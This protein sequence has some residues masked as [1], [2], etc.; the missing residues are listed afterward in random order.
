MEEIAIIGVGCKL[1][2][3]DNIDQ[4]WR[5]LENGENHVLEVP[6]DRWNLDAFY[7]PDP[8]APG[9]TYVRRAGFIKNHDA[10]DNKVYGVN[11]F[12]AS[13][14]DP[15][16]RFVLDCCFK[17]MEN[18]GVT[19][20]SV[21]GSNTGV[22]IG[23]M[24]SDY[25]NLQSTGGENMNNYTLTGTS[26]SIVAARI[27][28][29]FNLLG[30]AM[31]L[32]TACSS[33]LLAIHLAAQALR[34]GDCD[35]ALAGGVN[36][37]MSPSIFVQLSKAR[38]AS[39]TGYCQAFSSKADGYA[40][41]EGAGIILLK[42]L[43][44]AVRDNDPIWGTIMTGSN[45]DGHTVTPMTAPSGSQQFQLLKKVYSRYNIDPDRL[46]YIEAHGTGTQAGDP[47]EA[48]CLGGFLA[49]HTKNAPRYIGSVK[50]NIGH[51]ESA[52]GVAGVIKVLLMQKHSLI[53]PT[54]HFDTPNEKIDF[55]KLKLIVATRT[56]KWP[57]YNYDGT[58]LS[59]VNSFSF[60]GT[61]CHAIIKSYNTAKAVKVIDP[62][63]LRLIC[64][65]GVDET[66][67]KGSI[68]HFCEKVKTQAYSIDDVVF[69]STIRRD[70]Y[71]IRVAKV[72][73]SIDDAV[74]Q[75]E[76]KTTIDK[77]P[78]KALQKPKQIIFV[79]C[80][81]GSTWKGMCKEHMKTNHVFY[82]KILEVDALLLPLTGWS[83][84]QRFED[85]FDPTDPYLGPIASFT[86][87][88]ALDAVW[89]YWGI[90]PD[91]VV[92][93]SVGE[94]A[95]SY[96]AGALSLKDAVKVIY[97]RTYR[98]ANA[99]GGS[100]LVVGN[101]DVSEVQ[102]IVD[103]YEG[104]VVIAVHNSPKSCT[105]SGDTDVIGMVKSRIQSAKE[106]LEIPLFLH[107]LTVTSAFH[108]HHMTECSNQIKDDL[109]GLQGSK[110][111]VKL[112]STVSA[113][114]ATET[115]FITAEYWAKNVRGTVLFR[116]A[117]QDAQNPDCF[118]IF[119]E[120][121]P[122]PVLIA[123]SKENFD[124][125]QACVLISMKKDIETNCIMQNLAQLY[126][127]GIDP[128]WGN[129]AERGNVTDVPQY[130]FN[131]KSNLIIPE[132]SKL[133]LM[134]GDLHSSGHPFLRPIIGANKSYKVLINPNRI[135][136]VYEHFV[137]DNIFIPGAFYGEVGLAI[138]EH[139]TSGRVTETAVSI[140]F[141]HP[142]VLHPGKSVELDVFT[143][144]E[145]DYKNEKEKTNYTVLR[146]NKI[147]AVGS[148]SWADNQ[149][150]TI[151][152]IDEIRDRCHSE[153]SQQDIY[154]QLKKL[155]FSYG[156]P[157]RV[158][159][160]AVSNG[161]ECLVYFSLPEEIRQERIGTFIHPAI[162]DGM[163]QTPGIL[164]IDSNS[165]GT[166]ILP[167][168]IGRLTLKG[169]PK[170]NMVAYGK[171]VK[172]TE[173]T[174]HYD[175]ILL[176]EDGN[177]IAEARNFITQNLGIA[178]ADKNILYSIHWKRFN[179]L[180]TED[181][182]NEKL[183]EL[184][185]LDNSQKLDLPGL[186]VLKLNM[187]ESFTDQLLRL[188]QLSNKK[189]LVYISH[190]RSSDG[191]ETSTV[192]QSILDEC[193]QIRELVLFMLA[194]RIDIPL[195][196][197]TLD[198]WIL[199]YNCN[200][201]VG[202]PSA[203]A[204]WGML[205]VVD[206][207]LTE[208]RINLVD[209][210][211]KDEDVTADVLYNT[212]NSIRKNGE[213]L[214]GGEFL[215]TDNVVYSLEILHIADRMEHKYRE[216]E[217]D[218]KCEVQLFSET[219][220]D[221]INPFLIYSDPPDVTTNSE[222]SLKVDTLAIQNTLL[223]NTCTE[224]ITHHHSASFSSGFP[225]LCLE[226]IGYMN[227]M[228]CNEKYISC[229]PTKA[230]TTIVVPRDC[231]ISAE[232][233]PVYHPGLMMKIVLMWSLSENVPANGVTLLYNSRT[234][235]L[236][237]LMCLIL[238]SH[239]KTH[240][241]IVSLDEIE[242]IE[243]GHILSLVNLSQQI[244]HDII[245]N[246]SNAHSLITLNSL[247]D[248]LGIAAVHHNRP[249]VATQILRT[250]EVYSPA[251]LLQKVPQIIEWIKS[252]RDELSAICK[253]FKSGI[254]G[255][256]RSSVAI[257]RSIDIMRLLSVTEIPFSRSLMLPPVR[258]VSGN[259]FRKDA[260]YIV[261]GGLTG[262]GWECVQ[263]L[264][265][266][267]AGHV[268]CFNRRKP[269][270]ENLMNIYN[271]ESSSSCRVVTEQVDVTQYDSVENAFKSVNN[272]FP[273]AKI[274]G[275]IFGAAVLSDAFI[276]SMDKV[277]FA[278]ALSPK[279]KGAWN[280]HLLTKDL[281]LDYFVMHSS[282]AGLLGN[283]GQSNYAAGNAFEDGLTHF[284]RSMGLPGQSFNWG[285]L[286][287]G[288]LKEAESTVKVIN[289]LKGQGYELLE[290][291]DIHQC[292]M[293][294]LLDNYPQVMCTKL[295][296][297]SFS[298]G[299][300][301][302]MSN[303][304]TKFLSI[305][306]TKATKHNTVDTADKTLQ[307]LDIH[308]IKTLEKDSRMQILI[309]YMSVIT[310]KVFAIDKS[311]VTPDSSIVDLGIDSMLAMTIIDQINRD[312]QFR[313]PMVVLLSEGATISKIAHAI[314]ASFWE[315]VDDDGNATSN[316]DKDSLKE[317]SGENEDTVAEL[318]LNKTTEPE[319]PLPKPASMLHV[320]PKTE[321][322][323]DTQSEKFQ[324]S[325]MVDI[326]CGV[327]FIESDIYELYE[328][329][330]KAPLHFIK[331]IIFKGAGVDLD[332]IKFCARQI[333]DIH[334]IARTLFKTL[335]TKSA[336]SGLERQIVNKEHQLDF[337]TLMD[338]SKDEEYQKLSEE[339]FNLEKSG[340]VRFISSSS[341]QS[342][343]K[344]RLVCHAIGFDSFALGKFISDFQSLVVANVS[345]RN[346]PLS[347]NYDHVGVNELQHIFHSNQ[348]Q[349]ESFWRGEVPKSISNM[350]LNGN[351]FNSS[352]NTTS[353]VTN[354]KLDD[355]LSRKIFNLGQSLDT[356]LLKL[357]VSFYQLLLHINTGEDLVNV[358]TKI[359]LRH[360]LFQSGHEVCNLT[361]DIPLFAKIATFSTFSDFIRE[362]SKTIQKYLNN[363]IYP[364][365]LIEKMVLSD[366]CRNNLKR[367]CVVLEEARKT[368]PAKSL[369]LLH[370]TLLI[371]NSNSTTKSIDV[372]LQY[373]S[374]LY[375][376]SEAKILLDQLQQILLLVTSNFDMTII[377]IGKSVEFLHKKF[378]GDHHG[379]SINN[380]APTKEGAESKASVSG[381]V[382]GAPES[383][384]PIP[385]LKNPD[386]V[387]LPENTL[388]YSEYYFFERYLRDN[389]VG[390]HMITDLYMKKRAGFDK[391]WHN[392][393]LKFLER[394]RTLRT[395]YVKAE[396]GENYRFGFK[397]LEK[398]PEDILDF[399]YVKNSKD[400]AEF[401]KI[402]RQ[403][404]D[405]FK[406][407]CVR[408]IFAGEPDTRI[409]FVFQHTGVDFY[410]FGLLLKDLRDITPAIGY[411]VDLPPSP[412]EQT[413]RAAL[414]V[415]AALKPM[416]NEMKK[417]WQSK[418]KAGVP[419]LTLNK[420]PRD[421]TRTGDIRPIISVLPNNTISDIF[422]LMPHMKTTV[423]KF[424]ASIYQMYFHF[425]TGHEKV[426]ISAPLDL[427]T[428][429]PETRSFYENMM[430]AV[431]FFTEF[432]NP[433]QTAEEFIRTNVI[434]I[435]QCLANG[436]YSVVLIRKL[437]ENKEEGKWLTRHS[438]V[439]ED[440]ATLHDLQ[441]KSKQTN[442]VQRTLG[443]SYETRLMVWID[444][445]NSYIRLHLECLP[446]LYTEEEAEGH[447]NNIVK[448]M[449]AV[450]KNSNQTLSQLKEL[451][452]PKQEIVP[453]TVKDA[454]EEVGARFL[455]ETSLGYDHLV[456]A[457]VTSSS[458]RPEI[459]W[460]SIGYR[461]RS[462]PKKFKSL[463]LAE[464]NKVYLAVYKGF[465]TVVFETRKKKFIFKFIDADEIADFTR[466]LGNNLEEHPSMTN[467]NAESIH[468]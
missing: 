180:A 153:Y 345:N 46:E 280:L 415:E 225:V 400:D 44:D 281:N 207:E 130:H 51:L 31:A 365:S 308:L 201:A 219:K 94:V 95:A 413:G 380:Y 296:L 83:I 184:L 392:A 451:V 228:N 276:E 446:E 373:R 377:N 396:P 33:S 29:T 171:I 359:N 425:M 420:Y 152:D 117:L 313:I 112:Y 10:W 69:T 43:K 192:F 103:D 58:K 224:N 53:V 411:G 262:L 239:H 360:M 242:T 68:Q 79:F 319:E 404:F 273:G 77:V 421:E 282:I 364:Y 165:V 432:N 75:L 135:G 52:A 72:V 317:I 73:K 196:V 379:S 405:L 199:S 175:A 59:C 179:A 227:S 157:L 229:Y 236:M 63:K 416:E 459:K 187:T 311:M 223:Y 265:A 278:T 314:E 126:V 190:Q 122:K 222:V 148:I 183:S 87:Q 1:P 217:M 9:K 188:G 81:M 252:H 24:N 191:A 34:E 206:T 334:P 369:G 123:H 434:N 388:S 353:K 99:T 47:V 455:K 366:E 132:T 310:S 390:H 466:C 285:P 322:R 40:R 213:E 25:K 402:S 440:M 235:P 387:N 163:L 173:S 142:L 277:K 109:L 325:P 237:R 182:A 145:D 463:S 240:V 86:C 18:A 3:A 8:N 354:L 389:P 426:V 264:V 248:S 35:M 231:L 119:L 449:N 294:C 408:F 26:T 161:N 71:Q 56:D 465:R 139:L 16:Q 295:E 204:L 255:R 172:K 114:E 258:A 13:Q 436:L 336:K 442:D 143:S 28:F 407:G 453:D 203:A 448:L 178:S 269:S 250:E 297:G 208:F 42:R 460:A 306:P 458:G 82:K 351:N 279:V 154:G 164:D 226:A 146:D 66:S 169:A 14:M 292:L 287:I 27:S 170:D 12:E 302:T 155:G 289:I 121:G 272:S 150:N 326:E 144:V 435:N 419:N 286:N 307:R 352:T 467:G 309:D 185:I 133:A 371:V 92:G 431:P 84:C 212:I 301:S 62:H 198:T 76:S 270:Q 339:S 341:S 383:S 333:V 357:F 348:K 329:V 20:E 406:R 399:Q 158:L 256:R 88:V 343:F 335:V 422:K 362:N 205:R 181:A 381:Y 382:A 110:P 423:F 409:R 461:G 195:C 125:N 456:Y 350:N 174:T 45:Q 263:F 67:V 177:V 78:V 11:D 320:L 452:V 445:K 105:L 159:T 7:D 15:Q 128:N 106:D 50:T 149:E 245:G 437:L 454:G 189:A 447:M 361:N 267:G 290:I 107:D 32:D 384:M 233:L 111:D 342:S 19:R 127:H 243:H 104:K 36:S 251:M 398:N 85:S 48:N 89:K 395:V 230:G 450:L 266:N 401:D 74:D 370:D 298:S 202:N 260:V 254:L 468:A 39:P 97:H 274:K 247:I 134:G 316:E 391:I 443:F 96:S 318:N 259:M 108:S 193:M 337:R 70:H 321:T 328:H 268:V 5:V 131:P 100:M 138:A 200:V 330:D 30:P 439:E 90:K 6:S 60:G 375:T 429:L 211:G 49:D 291:D 378:A 64:F 147:L 141:K 197:I 340:P 394:H 331:D 61:N 93:Q 372:Q 220:N 210:S 102:K 156:T 410:A 253:S 344:V 167:V 2:G 385:K 23:V 457:K 116:Q 417:F 304:H 346:I 441:K 216:V 464:V 166:E 315:D 349:T 113:K 257:P 271:L 151:V 55:D 115:D 215:I 38:M 414:Y 41:G 186:N 444:K 284:R 338:S 428:H 218:E 358:I 293:S 367:H 305:L 283:H 397:K 160:D 368:V 194:K 22:Y 238:A 312:T 37:L 363:A 324:Q 299:S 65:S 4:F 412:S 393:A 124:L 288:M 17:A 57:T 424:F 374:S 137:L 98:Q 101:Y 136:S 327:S 21:H 91:C 120:I 323:M 386:T 347:V 80:G 234:K 433:D 129:V 438:V 356:T 209:I 249:H 332:V 168:Q 241:Q 430:S 303:L 176:T 418:I 427:R 118:N 244:I 261:V 54:L 221:Y 462:K 232:L 246:W 355:Q 162:L 275:V 376:S 300:T 403:S 214:Q 140:N